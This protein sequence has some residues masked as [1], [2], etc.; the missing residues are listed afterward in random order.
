MNM[1]RNAR[2]TAQI[3]ERRQ[4][5]VELFLKAWSQPAIARELGISQPTVSRDLQ[6]ICKQWRE[7]SI[8]DFD[9]ARERELQKL[10]VLEREAWAAWERSQQPVESTTVTQDG[11]GKK[12]QKTVEHPVGDPRYLEQIHK[13]IAGR[14]ALLGL[15]ALPASQKRQADAEA[16][17]SVMQ[18]MRLAELAE[19]R[20]QAEVVAGPP[21][22]VHS[23]PV[24]ERLEP[25]P[26]IEAAITIDV[27]PLA[28]S[29]GEWR[30]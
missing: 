26:K 12:A 6:A 28:G 25:D 1:G 19:L 11:S 4:D 5:V 13:C 14:R 30:C 20:A 23:E 16:A 15:D 21:L 7:S 3:A 29:N 8:R 22:L 24:E 18:L 17:L 9:A 27:P 10:E 2:E